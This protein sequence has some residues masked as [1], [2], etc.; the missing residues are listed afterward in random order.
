VHLRDSDGIRFRHEL[1][2]EIGL[3]GDPR[4]PDA[5]AGEHVA[6]ARPP[7][8]ADDDCAKILYVAEVW[9]T[10]NVCQPSRYCD[11]SIWPTIEARRS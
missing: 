9:S 4:S 6:L 10:I 1:A 8:G 7:V 2:G 11:G 3:S 5:A